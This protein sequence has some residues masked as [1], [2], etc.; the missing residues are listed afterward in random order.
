MTLTTKR[1]VDKN[2]K[3]IQFLLV[4]EGKLPHTQIRIYS[5]LYL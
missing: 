1:S 4:I 2:Y 3:E 5:N